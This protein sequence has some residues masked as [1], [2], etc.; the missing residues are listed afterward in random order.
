MQKDQIVSQVHTPQIKASIRIMLS[1]STELMQR[2]GNLRNNK[3]KSKE[4]SKE[5]ET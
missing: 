4:L 1:T 5:E 2:V 3:E